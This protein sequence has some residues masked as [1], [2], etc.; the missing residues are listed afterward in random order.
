M[1]LIISRV[2]SHLYKCMQTAS[3]PPPLQLMRTQ[4]VRVVYLCS[5]SS[6][7]RLGDR[8][9][10]LDLEE[11]DISCFLFCCFLKCICAHKQHINTA[12]LCR[13]LSLHLI[14]VWSGWHAK[15]LWPGKASCTHSVSI[16][17]FFFYSLL[18]CVTKGQTF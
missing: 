7:I 13:C 16:F 8:H 5:S 4:V 17:F 15:V 14:L 11:I 9:S 12:Y 10:C 18:M 6:T 3:S 2:N 1:S